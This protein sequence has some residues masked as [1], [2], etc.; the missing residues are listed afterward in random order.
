MHFYPYKMKPMHELYSGDSEIHKTFAFESLAR[1]EINVTWPWNI[2]W[3]DE[4]HFCLNG[5]VNSQTA[6]FGQ[7]KTCTLLENNQSILSQYAADL[8]LHL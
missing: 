7:V 8:L 3:S 1:M 2:L 4:A 5:Q 6:E